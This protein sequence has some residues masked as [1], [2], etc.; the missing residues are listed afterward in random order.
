M[1]NCICYVKAIFRNTVGHSTVKKILSREKT[2]RNDVECS[3][4]LINTE[5][6]MAIATEDM[7]K[8]LVGN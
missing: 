6:L 4:Y 5:L 2:V 1:Q 8:G 3:V 7:V